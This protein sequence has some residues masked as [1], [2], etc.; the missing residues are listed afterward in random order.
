[1]RAGNKSESGSDELRERYLGELAPLLE[2]ARQVESLSPVQKKR[3]RRR[4]ARTLFGTRPLTLRARLLTVLAALGLLVIGGAAFATAQRLGLLPK[5]GLGEAGAPAG[6]TGA[7]ARRRKPRGRVTAR[8]ASG[9]LLPPMASQPVAP[10]AEPPAVVLPEVPDPLLVPGPQAAASVPA[11]APAAPSAS[12]AAT[13]SGLL[14]KSEA[15]AAPAKAARLATGLLGKVAMAAPRPVPKTSARATE[16]PATAPAM[17]YPAPS[18]RAAAPGEDAPGP[19]LAMAGAPV[20]PPPAPAAPQPPAPPATPA[21]SAP[22]AAP[23]AP[24][25]RPPIA[26]PAPPAAAP[27]PPPALTDQALFGQALRKLRKEN[28]ATS[29]LALLREHA[30]AYPGS[31]LAGERSALEVEALLALHRDRDALALLD[32]MALDELPRSGERFVVRGELRAAARRWR[33][34]E[35]DFDRAL[36]GVSGSPAW[37]E[38]ALWG[39]GVAR[40]RQN[41]RE[42]GM[43]DITRYHDTYPK[44]RF[45]AEAAKFFP[46]K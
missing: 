34:A 25:V 32:G 29:A 7:E 6:D 28:D 8:P 33:E 46:K 3:V 39:R 35:A 11:P 38:R 12:P 13:V 26:A 4:I 10:S 24:A 36:A 41:E 30:G 20:A 14:V 27:A 19:A 21:V 40:L 16:T 1:M 43:A 45:A 44:G 31:A 18:S 5:L 9:D 2:A 23:G 42:S 22:Y 17:A 15:V 37:H